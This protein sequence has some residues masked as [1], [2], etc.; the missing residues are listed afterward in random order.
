MVP[1]FACFTLSKSYED[2]ITHE[3]PA[4]FT[5]TFSTW[6]TN[7][8]WIYLYNSPILQWRGK[9]ERERKAKK[10]WI[11]GFRA[12]SVFLLLLSL[13]SVAPINDEPFCKPVPDS[14]GCVQEE[15]G[16]QDSINI[17]FKSQLQEGYARYA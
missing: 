3:P 7:Y 2:V 9:T 12:H 5:A 16:T 8:S 15:W 6:L 17:L 1:C 10:C 13:F 11:A 14:S 4:L